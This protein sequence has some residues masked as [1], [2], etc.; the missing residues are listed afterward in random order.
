MMRWRQYKHDC[1]QTG[2][3]V[4]AMI[5]EYGEIGGGGGIF[6]E[7]TPAN[8]ELKE[9]AR[10]GKCTGKYMEEIAR[11]HKVHDSK[12]KSYNWASLRDHQRA[13]W[14]SVLPLGLN[15]DYIKKI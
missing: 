2:K 11:V 14:T 9:C 8:K 13:M 12:I 3:T 1:E 15:E 4:K 7:G 6:T 5:D 10:G